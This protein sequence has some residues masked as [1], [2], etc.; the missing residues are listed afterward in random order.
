[1]EHSE[2]EAFLASRLG[3]GVAGVTR[4]HGGE[5]STAYAFTH[6]GNPLVARFSR[7]DEDFAKDRVAADF[8][9]PGLPVPR[10]TEIGEAFDGY[11]AISERA[12]GRPLDSLSGA[13]L[14]ATFPSLLDAL[15]V[16]RRTDLRGASGFGRWAASGDAPFASWSSFLLAVEHGPAPISRISG[17]RE[18]LAASP[19]RTGP[20]DRAYERLQHLAGRLP[21][22]RHLV[23][24]DLLNG[25]VLVSGATVSAVL[26]WGNALYG[27]FLYDVAWFE[28]WSPW[29]PAWHGIDF[30]AEAQRHFGARGIDV[31]HFEARMTACLIQIGLD[32][33]AYSAFK[34]RWDDVEET[35]RRT[36][37]FAT[38]G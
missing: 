4:L 26:D 31:P 8:A 25:N 7:V 24:A 1:M 37:K 5:W 21:D 35:A 27:D 16:I 20:F 23:H 15:D 14:R 2:V 17:W 22:V 10:V 12:A 13:E 28:L 30:A 29:C 18:R 6:R 34:E 32:G 33:Q 36:L 3:G 38:A 19:T 11:F 9:A